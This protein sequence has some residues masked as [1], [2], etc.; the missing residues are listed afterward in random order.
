MLLQK[1]LSAGLPL[2]E[3]EPGEEESR[4]QKSSLHESSLTR[5]TE[6][7][8][9]ANSGLPIAEMA[10]PAATNIEE[11]EEER[12]MESRWTDEKLRQLFQ[13]KTFVEDRIRCIQV[14]GKSL[15]YCWGCGPY[16]AVPE[17]LRIDRIQILEIGSL[18]INCS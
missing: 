7:E 3:E 12:K 6:S 13:L 1:R 9:A 17:Q 18:E 8:A 4:L 14:R 15:F 5:S 2:E 11:G 10:S 16:R